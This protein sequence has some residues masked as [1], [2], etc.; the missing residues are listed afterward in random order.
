MIY[1]SMISKNLKLAKNFSLNIVLNL[2]AVSSHTR[3]LFVILMNVYIYFFYKE[4]ESLECYAFVFTEWLIVKNNFY[5]D[6]CR[7]AVNNGRRIK[8]NNKLCGIKF[9]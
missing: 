8:Y 7:N 3:R 9:Y 6:S 1:K 4:M 2:L 5:P